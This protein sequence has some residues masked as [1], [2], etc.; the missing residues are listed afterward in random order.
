MSFLY[1]TDRMNSR[2]SGQDVLLEYPKRENRKQRT[3][4]VEINSRD[5]N[6]TLFP[7]TTQFRWKFYRPLKD[8]V[9]IQIAGGAIPSCIYNL[10]TG[11]NSFTFEENTT[12]HTVTLPPGR[13]SL[14]DLV[15]T[16]SKL[17][18]A[19]PGV[20]NT[21]TVEINP[22]NGFMTIKRDSGTASFSLLFLTGNFVDEYDN[23]NA[24]RKMNSPAHILGFGRSDYTSNGSG[25]IT[26]IATVDVDCIVNR[27]YLYMNHENTQDLN[28]IER[29]VGRLQPH[30]ILY[31]D[32]ANTGYK[33]LNK[34]TFQPMFQA[35]PAPISRIATLD[36]ALRDEFDRLIELNGRDFT[37]LLEIVYLE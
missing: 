36:I 6:T 30:A 5:R 34:E 32:N 19:L 35:Y 23:N 12:R 13:Y 11:W 2:S 21:Y 25:V 1:S 18:N 29:S 7:Q 3:I 17:L 16:L 22:V 37:I 33:Y 26:G 8:V 28:T 31:M 24:L 4:L 10:C 9:Q 15:I 20:T 27:L 14:K